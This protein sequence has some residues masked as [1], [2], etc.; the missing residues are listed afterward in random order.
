M[1]SVAYC[2]SWSDE[3]SI[4]TIS[5]KFWMYSVSETCSGTDDESGAESIGIGISLDAVSATVAALISD[6]GSAK[7][8]GLLGRGGSSCHARTD[9]YSRN[10]FVIYIS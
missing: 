8:I 10:T 6:I 2:D 1:V 3:P 4:L 5:F 7:Q 9:G